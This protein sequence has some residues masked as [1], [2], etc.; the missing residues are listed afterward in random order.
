MP[1]ALMTFSGV[2]GSG[3]IR[4]PRAF[5]TALAL[6]AGMGMIGGS[7]KSFAVP[8]DGQDITVDLIGREGWVSQ[9]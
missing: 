4:T 2:I 8:V 6:A 1:T 9:K 3:V 5:A 7:P